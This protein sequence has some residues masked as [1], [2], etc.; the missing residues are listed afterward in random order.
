MWLQEYPL[1]DADVV[2]KKGMMSQLKDNRVSNA[3][4]MV[5]L[6]LGMD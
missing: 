1:N 4:H 3:Y 5:V 6:V 2:T